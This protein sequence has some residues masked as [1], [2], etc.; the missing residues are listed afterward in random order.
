MYGVLYSV[1]AANTNRYYLTETELIQAA[2]EK[3]LQRII[4]VIF[5]PTKAIELPEFFQKRQILVSETTGTSRDE[6]DSYWI[7]QIVQEVNRVNEIKKKIIIRQYIART[8]LIVGT[9]IIALLSSNLLSTKESLNNVSKELEAAKK[10]ES[11]RAEIEGYYY[12]RS[13]P[14]IQRIP[15]ENARVLR[16]E[17][18]KGFEMMIGYLRFD[19]EKGSGI[20]SVYADRNF[21]VRL[22]TAR[23]RAIIEHSTIKW[24]AG[25]NRVFKSQS[26]KNPVIY[27]LETTGFPSNVGFFIGEGIPN[28][29]IKDGEAT[30]IEGVMYYLNRGGY[31]KEKAR[32]SPP[33]WTEAKKILARFHDVSGNFKDRNI[34]IKRE[35]IDRWYK[36]NF[37]EIANTDDFKICY[38]P[39]HLNI[40]GIEVCLPEDMR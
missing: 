39:K 34:F 11:G 5:N 3:G 12:Y 28:E 30:K 22:N 26:D 31:S 14:D 18:G 6:R 13:T 9:V 2:C 19:K 1:E 4:T 40:S 24:E 15:E 27:S 25:S 29:N 20:Y 17:E 8:S 10:R 23:K 33:G 37:R 32:W 38:H 7:D 16:N 35:S 21:T 36:D